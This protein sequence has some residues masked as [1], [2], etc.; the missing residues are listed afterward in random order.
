MAGEICE[1]TAALT[2][3]FQLVT[4]LSYFIYYRGDFSI[5]WFSQYPKISVFDRDSKVFEAKQCGC[6]VFI[7]FIYVL[8][9][10]F[11]QFLVHISDNLLFFSDLFFPFFIIL[12]VVFKAIL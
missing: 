7:C 1:E 12:C 8:V 2:L 5:C 4:C 10:C 6:F 9:G 3:V 11:I